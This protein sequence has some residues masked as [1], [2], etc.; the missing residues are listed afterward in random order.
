MNRMTLE[1][2][3]PGIA[4]RPQSRNWWARLTRVPPECIHLDLQQDW[5][6][7]LLPDTLY[8]RGKARACRRPT[9]PQASLCRECCLGVLEPELARYAGRVVAFE[10]DGTLLSQYFFV[11]R[12]EFAAAGLRDEV[13]AAIAA[14]LS[15]CLGECGECSRPARWL[16]FPRRE[17]AGLDD[18][19]MIL[20][21]P[22]A[23]LCAA[24]GAQ[25]LCASLGALEE[26]NLFYLNVPYGEAGAYL[27]I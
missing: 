3:Y 24:H 12:E 13:S 17:V 14:R 7:T 19:A 26:A 20:A 23:Q 25:R 6:A 2:A 10:P 16:W 4:F 22:G 8:L 9:R 1:A 18:V 11:A 5:M 21:A 27:W 15:A